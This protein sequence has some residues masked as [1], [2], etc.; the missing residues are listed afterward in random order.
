MHSTFHH[1]DF[2]KSARQSLTKKVARYASSIAAL[3]EKND[4]TKHESALTVSFDTGYAK[5]IAK[6]VTSIG[7]VSHVVLVGI[8]GS[9][10]G[11]EAIY[12]ALKTPESPLLTVLDEVNEEKLEGVLALIKKTK[13]LASLAIVIV[14]K[15]GGTTET[16]FNATH[17]LACGEKK[18]G[19]EFLKRVVVVAD[20]DTSFFALAKKKKIKALSIPKG[21]GG[22]Y[23]VFTAVGVLP[24]S[25]LR[26]DVAALRKGAQSIFTDTTRSALE[27]AAVVL[28]LHA[29]QGVHTVNYFTFSPRLKAA[30]YWYRQ[31]LA[32][33][34]GKKQTKKKV[35]FEHSLLPTV[36]T[37]VDLHSMAQLY[38]GGYKNV[39]THFISVIS[40]ENTQ[41]SHDHWLLAHMPA[42]AQKSAAQVNHAITTGVEAAYDDQKLPYRSTVL[43]AL[44]AHQVGA[45]FASSLYEVMCLGHLLDVDPFDQPAVE[46]YKVHTKRNLEK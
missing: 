15:S 36:S 19:A 3:L 5:E 20:N 25:L 24:L 10:L 14:S 32:E 7:P 39:Y 18:F 35:P 4:Y 22:R 27:E 34:I 1:S 13:N 17:V 42:V 45:L 2:E 33:S 9:S 8:G 44:D 29:V 38:L 11:T 26:I 46:L 30:G 16:L 37:A 43:E 41:A 28:A 23:S 21:I 6:V 40:S 12:S 31:L